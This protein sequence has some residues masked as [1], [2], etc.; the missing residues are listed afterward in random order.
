MLFRRIVLHSALV[1][2]SGVVSYVCSQI[3]LTLD[4]HCLLQIYD[5][6]DS[7]ASQICE[8]NSS[9]FFF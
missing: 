1:H 7:L 9:P 4:W 8:F 3:F 6:L 5:L 2:F